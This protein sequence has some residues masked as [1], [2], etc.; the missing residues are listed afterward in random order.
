MASMSYKR[1]CLK[2]SEKVKIIEEVSLGAGVTQLAKKYGVSKATICKIKRMKRQLLQRTCNTFGGPGN[3]RTLKNAKAPKMEN[4]LYK[5][6]LQQRE[7]HVPISGEILKERAKLLNQ[8][9]KETE[10]FVASDGWLQRFKGRYGIRL[11]SISGEKLSA[12]PQLVQPFKE[13]LIKIIKELDLRMEQIYNADESGLYWKMLPEK[14][15]AASYE[16]SAPGI[17]TEKQRITFLA[18]TNANGSHKIKPLVIGKAQNPRSF[19][20]FKVPVDY[21]CSKT[22]WMTSGI[23]LKWFHK[24][25]V[26]Q[27]KNFL[28]EQKLPIKALL[29]LDNAPCHPPEQQLRSRDG[30]IFVMYMPPNVTSIIQPMD[31]NIIRLTK[32][33]Y[34]KFLLSSVLSKNPQNISDALKKVTLR[35]AVTDLHMAWSELNQETIAKCW[36]K[37]FSTNDEDNEEENV[38]LS[39]IRERLLSSVDSIVNSAS[40]DVV[41]LLKV[42]NPNTVCTS[43]DINIWNEDKLTNDATK[44]ENSEN[45][46]DDSIEAK[47]LVT[48]AQAVHIFNEALDWAERKEVSYADILVLRKLRAQALEDNA[49]RK[50]TQTKIADYFSSN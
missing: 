34:R 13:K 17:K 27:V 19:K 6:F 42:V 8:K 28:K 18:C 46:E 36:N 7:N 49:N 20:N 44:D 21:D 15:Y 43:A 1:K 45:D 29:L 35:E 9:L 26:P 32:L 31:Q 10:N 22:A 12:Q 2:L 24:R 16:K 4:S 37:L 33:Y 23:F 50:F 41:N 25:F 30:S 47:S 38:P 11:L 14:T 48:D 40:L 39:V 3:R 5:W